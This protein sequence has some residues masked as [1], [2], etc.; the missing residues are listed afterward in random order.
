MHSARNG[1][2]SGILAFAIWGATPIYFILVD[3]VSALE[4]LTHRIV[5]AL[6][7]AALIILAR[8]QW[9]DI[10][11][12]FSNRRTLVL[13]V[14]SAFFIS[15]N[16]LIFTWA[17][18][19]E[20]IFEASLGYYIN[21]LVLVLVGYLFLGERLRR[22]QVVAVILAT[23]GVAVLTFS[24]GDFPVISIALAFS[25]TLY[26]V[27]RKKVVV[28]ALPGLFVEVLVLFPLAAVYLLF[29]VDEGS[30]PF[31]WANRELFFLLLLAGPMTVLPLVFFSYAARRLRLATLGFIQFIGPTGQFL[32]GYYHG[33]VLTLPYLVCFVLIWSAVSLFVFDVFRAGRKEKYVRQMEPL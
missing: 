24:G 28:G 2:L 17:A 10:G 18:Q 19:N 15:V 33:E 11:Q 25:F 22:L 9:R 23:S 1:V 4:V 3:S 16:W 20:H 5:W 7:F 6:P 12:V 29:L 14:V 13:L 32:V 31:T 27:I 8:R 21:P 26:G 30:S